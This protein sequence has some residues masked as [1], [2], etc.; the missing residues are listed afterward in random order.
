MSNGKKVFTAGQTAAIAAATAAVVILAVILVHFLMKPGTADSGSGGTGTDAAAEA[1]TVSDAA[2]GSEAAAQTASA[3]SASGS[4][5]ESSDDGTGGTTGVEAATVSDA[6]AGSEA[7][8]VLNA[9]S[10]S[11][12][13]ALTAIVTMKNSWQENNR[14]FYQYDISLTNQTGKA[15]DDWVI[16]VDFGTAVSLRDSWNSSADVGGKNDAVLTLTG[17][18]YN[19]KIPAGG[20]VSDIGFILSAE[21]SLKDLSGKYYVDPDK[22]TMTEDKDAGAGSTGAA[23]AKALTESVSTAGT[24][25]TGTSKKE[26]TKMAEENSKVTAGKDTD[27]GKTPFEAHGALAV[28]DGK[29]VDKNGRPYQL[30]G[31][32]TH[33]IAWFPQYVN[34][35][36][37]RYLRDNWDVNLVRLA[38][39]TDESGG[40]CTDGD[41]KELEAVIDRGVKAADKLGMYVIIDWHILHDLTPVRYQP[42][43]EDFFKRMSA[44]YKDYD[45]VLYEI[46]NEP[47]GG[48]SWNEIKGYAEDI[49]PI[50]RKNDPDALILVGTPNWSQDVDAAAA[51][52]LTGVTNVAYTMHFYAAT[53]KDDLRAKL[54]NA[55]QQGLPV[56]ISEFSTCE[57]SGDGPVDQASADAWKNLINQYNLSYAD[58]SLSNKSESSA[59]LKPGCTSTEGGWTDADLSDTGLYLKNMLAE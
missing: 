24:A 46:C 37:F 33:G 22:G 18:D 42:Q 39:Y 5:Q 30:K 38:M 45:N 26:G 11:K 59:I 41:Q 16:A 29:I 19:A 15:L 14:F 10:D 4:G 32:S 55:V 31:V 23:K 57:A 8:T 34:E 12:T 53:H 27:G 6:P 44:K 35:K 54:E 17:A 7:V 21:E 1:V 2:A 48:T 40:Y 58:W 50:I 51:D 49:I 36:A 28:S 3:D 25:V 52:P 9:A 56:F 20:T 43:A 47:N 13:A